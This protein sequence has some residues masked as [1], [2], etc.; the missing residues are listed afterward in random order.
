MPIAKRSEQMYATKMT[1]SALAAWP[2]RRRLFGPRFLISVP[3]SKQDRPY[4]HLMTYRSQSALPPPAYPHVVRDPVHH[5]IPFSSEERK[6]IN[7]RPVQRLRHIHQ[8]ALTSLIYP[9]ATHMRFEHSLGVMHTAS[10]VYDGVT[11][12]EHLSD[13]IR[14]TGS[15]HHSGLRIRVEDATDKA[16]V[17]GGWESDCLFKEPLEELAAAA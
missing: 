1:E 5:W 9:G 7:S 14:E 13:Q 12:Q 10:Q 3:A 4:R 6:V 8:L 15:P 11:E 16:L 17:R 2:T